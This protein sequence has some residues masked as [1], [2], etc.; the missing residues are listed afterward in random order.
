MSYKEINIAV[1]HE[2]KWKQ[3]CG[4]GSAGSLLFDERLEVIVEY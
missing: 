1:H 2:T 4:S 3:C